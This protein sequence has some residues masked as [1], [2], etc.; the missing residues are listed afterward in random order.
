MIELEGKIND[1]PITILI[2]S[3]Y[4]HSHIDPNI[5]ERFHLKRSNLGKYWLV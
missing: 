5:V 1:K 2:G 3:I 4:S